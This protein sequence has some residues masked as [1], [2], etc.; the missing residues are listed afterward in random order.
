[1]QT[2]S[3]NCCMCLGNTGLLRNYTVKPFEVHSL[4]QPLSVSEWFHN[5][6]T[7]TD[8]DRSL[9]FT[10]VEAPEGHLFQHTSEMNSTFLKKPFWI[11]PLSR[12]LVWKASHYPA[13]RASLYFKVSCE[14]SCVSNWVRNGWSSRLIGCPQSQIISTSQLINPGSAT[15]STGPPETTLPGNRP[16]ASPHLQPKLQQAHAN[17]W[18]IFSIP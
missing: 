4:P 16:S 1:M 7:Y 8:K 3:H 12:S 10:S 5:R 13:H 6:I 9:L 18:S 17:I 11:I 15:I 2:W 14:G